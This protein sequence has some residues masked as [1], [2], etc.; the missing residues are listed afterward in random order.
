[1]KENQGT[2]TPPSLTM[3]DIGNGLMLALLVMSGT[4]ARP[5]SDEVCVA[6]VSNASVSEA[7][8]ADVICARSE[9]N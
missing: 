5:R 2:S 7:E 8:S 3:I 6:I 1:V 9:E 4:A